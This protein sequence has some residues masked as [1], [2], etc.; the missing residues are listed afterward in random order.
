M[1][2]RSVETEQVGPAGFHVKAITQAVM[3]AKQSGDRSSSA[4]GKLHL[5]FFR[6]GRVSRGSVSRG[7]ISRGIASFGSA[8]VLLVASIL[9][10]LQAQ[11]YLAD[12]ILRQRQVHILIVGCASWQNQG[13]LRITSPLMPSCLPVC[14]CGKQEALQAVPGPS[15]QLCAA[16][17][18]PI[19]A[20]EEGD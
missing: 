17:A 11:R 1:H 8:L 3:P 16:Q 6:E 14:P 9:H 10:G 12:L 7:R 5:F 13:C 2:Y 20:S 19:L 18:Q 15:A 4:A